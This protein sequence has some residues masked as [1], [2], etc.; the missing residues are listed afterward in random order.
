MNDDIL[1][2]DQVARILHLHPKTIRGFIREGK[3]KAKKLGKGW[4]IYKSDIESFID[5]EGRSRAGTQGEKS[6]TSIERSRI[7]KHE[8]VLVTSI[9][10]I[11]VQNRD[12]ADRISASIIGSSNTRDQSYGNVRIDYIYYE[13]EIKARFI[14]F[15]GAR[16]TS[17]L[18]KLISMIS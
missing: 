12:E 1:T 8:K 5:D 9:V 4:R 11:Y 16:F 7:E 18:L 13:T 14:V 17:D 6:D 3:L 15:G 2:V 10:D